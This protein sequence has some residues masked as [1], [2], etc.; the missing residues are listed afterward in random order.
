M[1]KDRSQNQTPPNLGKG[2]KIEV[3]PARGFLLVRRTSHPVEY[4]P[5]RLVRACVGLAPAALARPPRGCPLDH[6]ASGQRLETPHVVVA[7][8]DLPG[9]LAEGGRGGRGG[10]RDPSHS[11]VPPTNKRTPYLS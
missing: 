2:A 3:I 10:A 1:T 9:P 7:S 4:R 5:T 6:P 8:D 11:S